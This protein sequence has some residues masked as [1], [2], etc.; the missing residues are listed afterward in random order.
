[1]NRLLDALRLRPRHAPQD[2]WL[3]GLALVRAGDVPGEEIM[4]GGA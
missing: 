2:G 4:H 1:M 3:T